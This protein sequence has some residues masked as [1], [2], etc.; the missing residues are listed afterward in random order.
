[1]IDHE[2]RVGGRR[3]QGELDLSLM[4]L[5]RRLHEFQFVRAVGRY[6]GAIDREAGA[7]QSLACAWS[8][9]TI[10]NSQSSP[11]SFGSIWFTKPIRPLPRT[12]T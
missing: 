12:R 4:L 5:A 8:A 1:L 2:R 11:C 10:W 9:K 7:A 6:I 3:P